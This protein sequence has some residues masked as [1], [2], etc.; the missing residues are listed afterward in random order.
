MADMAS[1]AAVSH[2][3]LASCSLAPQMYQMAVVPRRYTLKWQDARDAALT[4]SQLAAAAS[5]LIDS[6]SDDIPLLPSRL[7]AARPW[8]Y[9]ARRSGSGS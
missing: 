9:P 4:L 6:Q 7:A 8:P 2:I 5:A 1:P 3:C